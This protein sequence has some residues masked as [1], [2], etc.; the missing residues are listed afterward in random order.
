MDTCKQTFPLR[1]KDAKQRLGF[2]VQ[3]DLRRANGLTASAVP[4]PVSLSSFFTSFRSLFV[5]TIFV[6]YRYVLSPILH[7]F[8]AAQN[9]ACRYP[10][11]CSSYSK[12]AIMQKGVI[13]GSALSLLR[14]LSCNPWM[15]PSFRL[16]SI[17]FSS[18]NHSNTNSYT[19]SERQIHEI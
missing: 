16:M 18:T 17:D 8:G 6:G 10:Q 1:S 14:I 11:N 7:I 13:L 9:G 3:E 15:Q 19:S 4:S 2:P 12:D 5:A